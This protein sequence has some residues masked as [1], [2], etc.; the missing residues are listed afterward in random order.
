MVY[1]PDSWTA[2][3]IVLLFSLEELLAWL[4]DDVALELED[5]SVKLLDDIFTLDEL[6]A[7]LLD[8]IF[9]MLEELETGLHEEEEISSY[10]SLSAGAETLQAT[11]EM[12]MAVTK[13]NVRIFLI[14]M[15]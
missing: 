5:F 11:V 13:N 12:E 10:S 3:R 2:S 15:F 1:L 8:E 4:L 9:L 14:F 6:W 7:V